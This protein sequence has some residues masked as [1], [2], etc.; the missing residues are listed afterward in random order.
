MKKAWTITIWAARTIAGTP[1]YVAD[2][3][4]HWG[5]NWLD[6][7]IHWFASGKHVLDALVDNKI[8]IACAWL[9]P[10][11]HVSSMH[12]DVMILN[13]VTDSH[14]TKVIINQDSM[15]KEAITIAYTKVTA[16]AECIE[17]FE[18]NH[19]AMPIQK[20]SMEPYDMLGAL[21]RWTID[22]Y[23]FWEPA[24]HDAKTLL[25]SRALVYEKPKDI[26]TWFTCLFAR[27]AFLSYNAYCS[28][29]MQSA[30]AEAVT[31]IKNHPMQAQSICASY[32]N[33][34]EP[35][36]EA[37]RWSYHFAMGMDTKVWQRV[38]QLKEKY[39]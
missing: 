31:Y 14:D 35:A 7:K 36:V 39:H 20:I 16:S 28:E 4:G 21:A 12:D 2:H 30:L 29:K 38:A 5:T 19:V 17:Q 15:T 10:Y 34:P 11:T 32:T 26:Y 37:I 3:L 18:H 8:D 24:I 23:C 33:V 22:G 13:K 25:W 27:Q 9:V 1:L 6:A